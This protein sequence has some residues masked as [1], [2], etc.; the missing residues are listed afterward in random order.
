MEIGQID[1]FQL[2]LPPHLSETDKKLLLKQL[3]DFPGASGFFGTIRDNEPVQGDA[4]RGF[5]ALHYPSGERDEVVGLVISNSCDITKANNPDPDQN[6]L[7]APLLDLA[8]Y[9]A[10]LRGL[11]KSADYIANR[12]D[13]IRQQEIHR[14]FYVPPNGDLGGESIV[15]LDHIYAQPLSSLGKLERVFSLSSYGW[16]V[17]LMKLSVHFTRMTDGVVREPL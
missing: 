17:L 4:W 3:E 15:L 9:Q 16:Y 1:K 8:E 11:G 6:V 10:V 5:V 13:R 14:I 2:A 7:F 12:I